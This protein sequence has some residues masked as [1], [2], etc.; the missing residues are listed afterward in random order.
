M[1]AAK[2]PSAERGHRDKLVDFWEIAEGSQILEIGCGQ[3]DTTEALACAVGEHG[4]V[5]GI[6]CAGEGYGAPETLGQARS[7]MLDSPNGSRIK[8]DFDSDISDIS[9]FS[10]HGDDSCHKLADGRYDYAVLSH[11]SWYFS[12]YG[13]LLRILTDARRLAVTLCFAEWDLQI[14]DIR[15]L[16]HYK[17]VHI[18]AILGAYAHYSHSNIRTLFHRSEIE[19]ALHDSGWSIVRASRSVSPQLQ[20]A[21]WERG[22]ALRNGKEQIETSSYPDKFREY[23]LAE[24]AEL[25]EMDVSDALPLTTWAIVA[26]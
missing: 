1:N 9:N 16:C 4:F 7:R 15:Q 12:S 8:M 22:N 2:I 14:T 21:I 3:G 17:A 13:E 19:R 25:A 6:D 26:E 10:G 24:L 18:Q 20:D 5:H 23:L 11:C